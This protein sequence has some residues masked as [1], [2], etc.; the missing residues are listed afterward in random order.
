MK[1]TQGVKM[2]EI[3]G[4]YLKVKKKLWRGV[5]RNKETNQIV[6]TCL[7]N[8]SRPEFNSRYE[9]PSESDL[10]DTQDSA[11]LSAQWRQSVDWFWGV[12]ET[13][14]LNCGR[15]AYQQYIND[16]A[17]VG[18]IGD[19]G[20]DWIPEEIRPDTRYV[21]V[22]DTDFIGVLRLNDN[23]HRVIELSNA[24]WSDRSTKDPVAALNIDVATKKGITLPPSLDS[25]M[26]GK[27][28]TALWYLKGTVFGVTFQDHT[29]RI[30]VEDPDHRAIEELI[31]DKRSKQTPGGLQLPV[32][33]LE[34]KTS[35][36]FYQ[37]GSAPRI[38][39]ADR[40]GTRLYEVV[41]PDGEIA[42]SFRRRGEAAE[43]LKELT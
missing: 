40:Q 30:S 26:L 39:V 10:V 22:G 32:Q 2:A 34:K 33:K 38:E 21:F 25:E 11:E 5:L 18:D 24:S 35:K 20:S 1:M 42:G 28:V 31:V 9:K 36:Q 27:V 4:G 3:V 37:S 6:W 12:W 29:Y 13:S 41:T 16:Q 19:I 8:H 17:C 43:K 23:G 14:A 7:H 15:A